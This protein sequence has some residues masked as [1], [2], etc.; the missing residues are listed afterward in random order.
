M[1]NPGETRRLTFHLPVDQ[2]AFYDVDLNLV[3]EAGKIDVMVGS[4]SED[5][6]QHG[7]FEIIGAEKTR[8]QK[9]VF[10]CPVEIQ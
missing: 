9:R 10:V 2:L 6:R 7:T 3:I 4:S 8:I 5:I 1:L